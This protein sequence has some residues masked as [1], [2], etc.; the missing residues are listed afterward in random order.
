[1]GV[2]EKLTVHNF[3]C[4]EN[5]SLSALSKG[6]IVLSGPN[7]IGKT[8]ILEAVSF[9]SP[10]RGLR[11]ARVM[12]AQSVQYSNPWAVSGVINTKYGE[13]RLGTGLDPKSRSGAEKRTIRINGQVHKSQAELGKYLSCIWLTPQMDRLFLDSSRERLS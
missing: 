5:A 7:G 8:N 12:E 2:L 9:L 4:Y 11:G 6:L 3:R 13:I 10:G 1:M